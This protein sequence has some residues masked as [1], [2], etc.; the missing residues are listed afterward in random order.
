MNVEVDRLLKII[1]AKEVELDIYRENV[2]S[3]SSS[4]QKAEGDIRRL[5]GEMQLIIDKPCEVGHTSP[6]QE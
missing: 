4:L 1:G 5:E 6:C 2:V 3:L